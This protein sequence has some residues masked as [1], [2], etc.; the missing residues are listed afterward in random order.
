MHARWHPLAT[1]PNRSVPWEQM[2]ER[3]STPLWLW[4]NLLSLD[5]PLVA[6]VWQDFLARC[7]SSILLPPGRWAL[8]LTVWAIYLADRLMDVRH[9]AAE[10]ETTR[11]QFY[12]Q[13]N[14]PAKFL[15]AA[16]L[17]ADLLVASFWLR[18]QV[19]T[20]GLWTGSAVAAYLAVFAFWRVGQMRWKQPSAALLFTC[21]IFLVAWTSTPRPWSILWWPGAAFCALCL[22]NLLLVERWEQ[23]LPS[24]RAWL[25]MILLA[26]ICLWLGDSRWYAAIASAA[27]G[28][29]VLAL[30][31]A[32]VSDDV[33]RVL[34]DVALLTPLLFR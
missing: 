20:S 26:A 15:L 19:F 6:I 28:M 25:W 23:G 30:D 32:R 9:A 14:L 31:H 16:V 2:K 17:L 1:S 11:H 22:G 24:A 33:R 18:P 29:A 12:R 21:G 7:Y 13:N 10:H 3:A 4:L 34:A 27:V 5:A 8:G